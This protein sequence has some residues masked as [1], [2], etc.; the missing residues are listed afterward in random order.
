MQKVSKKEIVNTWMLKGNSDQ[1]SKHDEAPAE[2][3]QRPSSSADERFQVSINGPD[4]DQ[5][6]EIKTRGK[7]LVRK[8]LAAVCKT[9]NLDYERCD[10]LISQNDICIFKHP[11]LLGLRFT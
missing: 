3:L 6:A 9:F 5:T 8:V 10:L 7:H 4:L 2:E 1:G 11:L